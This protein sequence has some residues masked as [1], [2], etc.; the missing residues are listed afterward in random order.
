MKLMEKNKKNIKNLL[1][2]S[3]FFGLRKIKLFPQN[4]KLILAGVYFTYFIKKY[5]NNGVSI[6]IP[7]SLTDFKF[8]GRFVFNNYETE[9]AEYLSKYLPPEA[10]VIELGGCLGFVSCLT[11][12]ILLDKNKH[13]VLEANP[14]LIPLIQKNKEDNNCF[15]SIENLVVTKEKETQ[16]YIHDLI[17]GGSLKRKTGK[18]V[19]IEGTTFDSLRRKYDVDFDTLIMDIEGG[20]LELFRN[21]KEEIKKFKMIFFEVHPFAGILTKEEAQEC[22]E[23]LLGLG[24]RIVKRDGHFQVWE[25]FSLNH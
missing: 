13:I 7:F 4:T 6:T 3:V 5:K 15:F 18:Q 25:K 8:R 24:F 14:N 17:V 21:H 16:F 22:E 11:N 2:E 23:I 9:E 10:T 12:K 19:N 1:P 20:E